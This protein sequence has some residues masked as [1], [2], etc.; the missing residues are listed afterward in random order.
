M[1]TNWVAL[2]SIGYLIGSIPTG[3]LVAKL[4]GIDDIRNYGSGNIGATNVARVL[5]TH[6]FFLILFLDA[7]KAYVFLRYAHGVTTHDR[8]LCL[9]GLAILLG[10][11]AS[12]FLGFRGG[13]GV[14]TCVGIV[15]ALMPSLMTYVFAVW[16]TVFALT[17]TIGI[18]SVVGCL[19]MPCVAIWQYGIAHV[20]AQTSIVMMITLLV[21]HRENI[22]RF[23]QS[24]S[25]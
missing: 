16:L 10:N 18:A 9:I 7:A 1:M 6:F 5:G 4:A 22:V 11:I 25:S 24:L 19:A 12:M 13:K 8:Y 2:S 17:Q 23:V 15:A 20:Y 21:T 3:Y 14:A